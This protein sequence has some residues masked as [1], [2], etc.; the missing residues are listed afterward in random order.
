MTTDE[1]QAEF[2]AWIS[3]PPFEHMCDKNGECSAWP[4]TYKRYETEIAWEAWQAAHAS[5]DAEVE[6]LKK[7]I[8]DAPVYYM[9]TKKPTD[10]DGWLQV[11]GSVRA[12]N[13]MQGKHVRL[14]IDDEMQEER[15]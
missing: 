15:K 4:G 12:L 11:V 14:V 3:A 1:L 8:E 9:P 6:A 10:Q 7:C 2:E 13:N 5:R